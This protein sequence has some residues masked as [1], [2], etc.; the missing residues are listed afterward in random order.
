MPVPVPVGSGP[1]KSPKIPNRYRPECLF[2]VPV[3]V[4][5]PVP[6]VPPV[7][8]LIPS[9]SLLLVFVVVVLDLLF[10]VFCWFLRLCFASHPLASF[11]LLNIFCAAVQK[12]TQ[13]SILVVCVS[14][15]MCVDLDKH[16][17]SESKE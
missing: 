14:A 5:V 6:S 15:R 2:P 12:K 9:F 7:L 10:R 11:T 8:L 17:T 13:K 1:E 16:N 4:P 3:P